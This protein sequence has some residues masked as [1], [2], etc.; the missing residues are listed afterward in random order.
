MKHLSFTHWLAVSI[1]LYSVLLNTTHGY[2]HEVHEQYADEC[3]L[4]YL[5]CKT[6]DHFLVQLELGLQLIHSVEVATLNKLSKFVSSQFY[7]Y[8]RAP[9]SSLNPI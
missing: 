5:L 2:E 4:C 3:E 7:I 6:P 1:F 9:P 8:P